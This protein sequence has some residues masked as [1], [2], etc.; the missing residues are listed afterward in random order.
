M[1]SVRTLAERLINEV[2]KPPLHGAIVIELDRALSPGTAH[3]GADAYG[4]VGPDFD[5]GLQDGSNADKGKPTNMDSAA[6]DHAASDERI[7]FHDAM[8]RNN[9]T[10]SEEDAV[11]YAC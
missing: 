1:P 2:D 9:R 11:N 4:H 6:E 3:G 7:I 8:V 5:V 10:S